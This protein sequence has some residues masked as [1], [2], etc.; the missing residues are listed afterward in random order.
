MFDRTLLIKQE[1]VVKLNY[2]K[3]N[4]SKYSSQTT[5]F[6]CSLNLLFFEMYFLL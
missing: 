3:N 2:E 4:I 6:K 5:V 1:C